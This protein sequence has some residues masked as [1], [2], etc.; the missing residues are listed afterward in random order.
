MRILDW[1]PWPERRLDRLPQAHHQTWPARLAG[2]LADAVAARR[3]ARRPSPPEAPL[4]VSIGNLRI[5]GTGKTPVVLALAQGL[6]AHGV[7]AGAILLRGVGSAARGPLVVSATDARAADEARFLASSLADSGWQV[8]QSRRRAAGLAQLLSGQPRP[9]VVLLEDGFQTAGI[10][11][12]LDVLILD[13]WTVQDGAVVP[14]SA[15]VLP[16][17]PYRETSRGA[18]RAEVW[19]LETDELPA[20]TAGRPLVLGFRRRHALAPVLGEAAARSGAAGQRQVWGLLAGVARPERFE[21]AA[22]R[23]LPRVPAVS[24][25]CRDHYAYTPRMVGRILA[26]GSA[27]GVTVWATTAKDWVKL[28]AIWPAAVPVAIVRQEVEWTGDQALPRML[29][30]RLAA[31]RSGG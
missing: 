1:R 17:G 31:C 21:A 26:A 22:G 25:R 23:L 15:G 29:A 27:I 12:H 10:G 3:A 6:H 9:E 11:R 13:R 5:G 19:L 14:G 7:A 16:F 20:A 18:A 30:E 4:V 28:Q 2:R 8:V 24:V